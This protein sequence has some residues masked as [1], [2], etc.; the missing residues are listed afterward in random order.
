MSPQILKKQKYT[1]KTD[2]FSIAIIYYEM[3][4]GQTPWDAST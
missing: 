4:Y 2:I 1:T 3:L